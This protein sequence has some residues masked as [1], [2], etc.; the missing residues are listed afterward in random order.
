MASKPSKPGKNHCQISAII[1]LHIYFLNFA[2]FAGHAGHFFI[3]S[4]LEPIITT[5][6]WP[7]KLASWP[8]SG[9]RLLFIF[10]PYL[11]L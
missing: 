8:F 7:A 9:F 5:F 2:G 6:M 4:L 11:S 3:S 1:T 10:H